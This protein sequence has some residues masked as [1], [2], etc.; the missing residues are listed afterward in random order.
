VG[1]RELA[2]HDLGAILEDSVSGFGWPIT[3]TDPA[4]LTNPNLVGFSNDIS[5]VI[6]PDTGQLVSGRSASVA[7]RISSLIAAGFTM[8]RG[9]ADQSS[10][11]WLV[12]FNDINGVAYTFK[13]RQADPD[14]ALGMVVCI[15]EG[16]DA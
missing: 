14:R 11:P 5:Q 15:L 4:G 13:V 3:L 6:D 10:K 16:Y 12:A 7:L 1:L 8:P 9:I 2:E